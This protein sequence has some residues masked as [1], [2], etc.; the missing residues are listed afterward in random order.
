M[1]LALGEGTKNEMSKMVKKEKLSDL[2]IELS[3]AVVILKEKQKENDE[4]REKFLDGGGT[5]WGYFGAPYYDAI[6]EAEDKV[7][8]IK[9]KIDN[10]QN[11]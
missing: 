2:I 11:E 4:A 3:E 7:N 10:Y 5:S 1:R 9:E 6:S 8:S